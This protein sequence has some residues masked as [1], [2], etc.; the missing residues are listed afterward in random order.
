MTDILLDSAAQYVVTVSRRSPMNAKF[1]AL[2][3]L[4]CGW[5][6][7]AIAAVAISHIPRSPVVSTAIRSVGYSKRLHVLEIEFVNGAIYRYLQVTRSVYQALMTADSKARYYDKNVKG[8]YVSVRMR[9]RT[10]R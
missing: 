10:K 1:L 9:S 7:S 5:Q 8:H 3:L 4:V 6:T 2:I